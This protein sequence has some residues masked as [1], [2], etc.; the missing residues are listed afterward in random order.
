MSIR[1]SLVRPKSGGRVRGPV[2][3]RTRR[4]DIHGSE[5]GGA[6]SS[7]REARDAVA[8]LE[9]LGDTDWKKVTGDGEMDVV[10]PRT[11]WPGAEAVAAS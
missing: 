7:S 5:D 6:A 10:G 11:I 3:C 2:A 4:E 1:A 8:T 9:K